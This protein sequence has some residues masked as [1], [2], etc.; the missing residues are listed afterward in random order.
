MAGDT[1]VTIEGNLIRD[2]ELAFAASGNAHVRFCVAVGSRRKNQAGQWEDGESA[3]WDCVA[4]KKLAENVAESLHKGDRVIVT[5][6]LKPETY[7]KDGQQRRSIKVMVDNIGPSL[8]FAT[9]NVTKAA[10]SNEQAGAQGGWG[11]DPWAS[12]ST[13]EAP[14]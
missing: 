6:T 14:F 4:F 3:F 12:G 11:G 2:P 8:L 9:A 10:R 13:D 7:E 1:R 5:G